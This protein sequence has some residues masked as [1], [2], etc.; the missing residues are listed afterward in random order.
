MYSIRVNDV[1]KQTSA[2]GACAKPG[3]QKLLLWRPDAP[4]MGMDPLSDDIQL[5]DYASKL[6]IEARVR[7]AV[8]LLYNSGQSILPDP[9]LMKNGWVDDPCFWPGLEYPDI[10]TYLIDSPGIYTKQTLKAYKSLD[11][12]R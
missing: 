10:W 12:Y 2:D 11:A 5:S 7:Y 1:G 3:G 4:W 9:Y 6:P 8:K